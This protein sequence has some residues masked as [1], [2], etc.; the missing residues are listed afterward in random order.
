MVI[1][2]MLTFFSVSTDKVQLGLP[3][4]LRIRMMLL[5]AWQWQQ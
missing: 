2:P 4:L 1:F 3:V 5:S